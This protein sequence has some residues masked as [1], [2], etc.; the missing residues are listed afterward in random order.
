MR[1]KSLSPAPTACMV[2]VTMAALPKG[3]L[4]A[5]SAAR[6]RSVIKLASMSLLED[7]R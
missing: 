1:G 5:W 3:V 6:L 7:K 4:M 2:L